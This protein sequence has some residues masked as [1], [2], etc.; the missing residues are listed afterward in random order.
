MYI[1]LL[2]LVEDIEYPINISGE[3]DNELFD[4]RNISFDSEMNIKGVYVFNKDNIALDATINVQLKGECDRCRKEL[5]W[6]IS[7]PLN[8]MF[9]MQESEDGFSYSGTRVELDEAIREKI[10]FYLPNQLLCKNDC[11]GLCGKCGCDFNKTHCK[12][13]EDIDDKNPFAILKTI[14]GGKKN[15]ST[16]M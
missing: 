16:K 13:H 5:R 14:V 4:G 15:G 12:C 10:M 3:G 1:D 8:E 2:N 7:L 9:T 11:K 6:E